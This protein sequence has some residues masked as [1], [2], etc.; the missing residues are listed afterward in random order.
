MVYKQH[1][2]INILNTFTLMGSYENILCFFW[3]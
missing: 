2:M 3:S 1:I